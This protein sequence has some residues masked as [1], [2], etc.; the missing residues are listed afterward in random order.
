MEE[1]NVQRRTL[2]FY[3][4]TEIDNPP[5]FRDQLYTLFQK[6]D[7]LGRVYIAGEGINAQISVPE[8]NFITFVEA[9]NGIEALKGVRI[10]SAIEDNGKSFYV[11]KIKCRKKI[12]ADGL[13]DG[14]IDF[15]KN[16]K[17]ISPEQF[18]NLTDDPDTIVVDMR[19]HYESE[20]G[21]FEGAICPDVLTFK[22]SLPV[23]REMLI[24]K[25]ENKI[26]MYCTGG[27]RCEKASA[28][29]VNSGFQNVFQLDG[30]IIEYS[31]Q[32]KEKGME[33]KFK[34]KNFVFDERLGE[35]I[36]E[37]IISRCHQCDALCDTH[38]NC[39]NDACHLLFIQC[40]NCAEKYQGCCSSE[41]MDFYLLPD[42]EQRSKRK[43]MEFNGTRFGKGRYRA[44]RKDHSLRD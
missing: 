32:V 43:E 24:D 9:L 12:V 8:K 19:N 20:V 5:D 40:K 28:Y 41:C 25:Q 6:L 15:S 26:V 3:R 30:G 38:T 33:N 10:N 2:S 23:V 14:S 22:E 35:R 21:H 27:I 7:I 39:S 34:G 11:L 17:H 44:K 4:Y 13:D 42:E 36:S 31:R 37:D 1:D 18:N 16:G 29:F